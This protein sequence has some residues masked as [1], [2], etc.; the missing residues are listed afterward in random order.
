M[1]EDDSFSLLAKK[2]GGGAHHAAALRKLSRDVK[3]EV[4]NASIMPRNSEARTALKKLRME[5]DRFA[6]AL[7]RLD[8]WMLL[9][10]PMDDCG[11]T[12]KARCDIE[13]L[14]VMCDNALSMNPPQHGN[15]KPGM[16]TCA[17]IVCEVWAST[18]KRAPGHNNDRAHEA[19]ETYWGACGQPR[20]KAVGRWE[21]YL[22]RA[23]LSRQ[24]GRYPWI[25]QEVARVI[26]EGK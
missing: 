25:R 20:S 23:R 7:K 10:L 21:H 17:L 19:C 14:R 8:A 1:P 6:F 18:H 13:A 3:I 16:V 5:C 26:A 11:I 22:K 24:S 9:Y 12:D 4:E 15:R 2:M